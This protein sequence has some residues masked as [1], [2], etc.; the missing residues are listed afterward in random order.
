MADDKLS[1]GTVPGFIQV[2]YVAGEPWTSSLA[3]ET[4]EGPFLWPAAPTLEFTSGIWLATLS[5]GDTVATWSVPAE[6][7]NALH[8]SGDKSLRLRVAGRTWFTGVAIGH[9]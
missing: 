3:L 9:G 4:A 1:L 8:S 5:E 2:D 7:V 6:Q